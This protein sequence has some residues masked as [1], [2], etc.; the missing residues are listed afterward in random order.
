MCNC[1]TSFS[2]PGEGPCS[3]TRRRHHFD[4][5]QSCPFNGDTTALYQLASG[6]I[7]A[8]MQRWITT[9]VGDIAQV[10]LDSL[11]CKFLP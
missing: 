1:F 8:R 11:H 10:S 2:D 6:E 4:H 3:G 5:G 7:H 9:F